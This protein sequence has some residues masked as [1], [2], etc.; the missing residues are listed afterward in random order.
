M[1]VWHINL[2]RYILWYWQ[3]WK[4]DLLVFFILLF[5]LNLN[6]IPK[7]W[8]RYSS[9]TYCEICFSRYHGIYGYGRFSVISRQSSYDG[10]DV[11]GLVSRC[12][13]QIIVQRRKVNN[14]RNRIKTDLQS[15]P[16]AFNSPWRRG[17]IWTLRIWQEFE[18]Q[19]ALTGFN[20]FKRDF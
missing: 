2:F 17:R 16:F 9:I 1:C 7:N 13:S 10:Y 14:I 20:Q 5:I 12:G 11:P 18:D 15:F 4:G 8:T 3:K 19:K 6:Y